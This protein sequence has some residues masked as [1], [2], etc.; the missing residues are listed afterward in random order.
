MILTEFVTSFGFKIGATSKIKVKKVLNRVGI[1]TIL[2]I[3][4]SQFTTAGFLNLHPT[5]RT[6]FVF[7][8]SEKLFAFYGLP[9]PHYLS[10]FI[11]RSIEKCF[12][13]M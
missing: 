3:R 6:H 4:D 2:Y 5:R 1:K 8:I 12:L 9:P 10:D 11:I 13:R 7:Y